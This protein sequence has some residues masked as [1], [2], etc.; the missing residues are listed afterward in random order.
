MEHVK[1]RKEVYREKH[2]KKNKVEEIQLS[3]LSNLPSL[4]GKE[5]ENKLVIYV[6]FVF[7]VKGTDGKLT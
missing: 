1:G 2:E 3:K 5:S 4:G 7:I 6:R